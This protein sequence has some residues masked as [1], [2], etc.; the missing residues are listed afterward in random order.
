[1]L[2]ET[3]GHDTS[4]AVKELFRT[5]DASPDAKSLLPTGI[6]PSPSIDES[7]PEGV[8]SPTA[9]R[10]KGGDEVSPLIRLSGGDSPVRRFKVM[11]QWEGVVTEVDTEVVVADIFDFT[12]SLSL[13]NWLIFR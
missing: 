7:W 10:A 12:D 1:M 3:L 8:T 5:A 2:T 11:Q 4:T 9:Q 6:L 13:A